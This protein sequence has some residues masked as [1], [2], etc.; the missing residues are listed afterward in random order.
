MWIVD[1]L[2]KF[3]REEATHG[4]ILFMVLFLIAVIIVEM[5]KR[6]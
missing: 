3:T 4:L 2:D 6:K 1:F 5:K